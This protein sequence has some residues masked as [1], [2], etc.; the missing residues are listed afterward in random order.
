M[1]YPNT[2][3]K[4]LYLISAVAVG[5]GCFFAYIFFILNIG[6]G[7]I[8]RDNK[9]AAFGVAILAIAGILLLLFI[10]WFIYQSA[11]YIGPTIGIIIV[12]AILTS[13]AIDAVSDVTTAIQKNRAKP[14]VESYLG[15]LS[16][17]L[18]ED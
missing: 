18:S 17:S 9:P 3:W 13:P 10:G 14:Y 15:K 7:F 8:S 11:S 16:T 4:V 2:I 6:G 12:A 5:A 1:G